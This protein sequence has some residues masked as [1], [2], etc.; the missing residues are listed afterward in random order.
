MKRSHWLTKDGRKLEIQWMQTA[1][2]V[3][4]LNMVIRKRDDGIPPSCMPLYTEAIARGAATHKEN[5]FEFVVPK[6]RESMAELCMLRAIID[7]PN[8]ADEF[9][10]AFKADAEGFIATMPLN[11]A[12]LAQ[13]VWTLFAKYRLTR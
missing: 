9:L 4:A 12:K 8:A 3:N 11:Q 1:H 6:Q 10:D 13:E 5:S 2:L 7:T